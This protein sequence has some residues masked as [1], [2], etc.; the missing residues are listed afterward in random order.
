MNVCSDVETDSRP[1]VEFKCKCC[2]KMARICR[3]CWRNQRYCSAECKLLGQR[4]IKRRSQ[5]KYRATKEG[6]EAHR[7][8]QKR[9]RLH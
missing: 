9:Y 5:R 7:A 2:G 1:S 3:T 4:E 8:A 6:S